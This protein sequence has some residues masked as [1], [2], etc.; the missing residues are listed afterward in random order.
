VFSLTPP[1]KINLELQSIGIWKIFPKSDNPK[2]FISS[3]RYCCENPNR[4]VQDHL[5]KSL[6]SLFK[7]TDLMDEEVIVSFNKERSILTNYRLII[8]EFDKFFS[9]PLRNI[10]F[11][12]ELIFD[13]EIITNHSSSLNE[14]FIYYL[15]GNNELKSLEKKVLIPFLTPQILNQFREDM[16]N[17]TFET[18]G[19]INTGY[20]SDPNPRYDL[21]IKELSEVS[22]DQYNENL[23]HLKA[24]I[25]Y[26][27]GSLIV[28]AI[29]TDII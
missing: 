28:G 4:L 5:K 14:S 19:L 8:D 22:G 27:D 20:L 3:I 15:D 24:K 13:E 2:F 17:M 23:S 21:F 9:I 6:K 7:L 18:V 26:D 1:Y 10:V 11:W 29:V 12:K 16:I 25:N